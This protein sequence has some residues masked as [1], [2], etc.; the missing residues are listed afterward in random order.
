MAKANRVLKQS[1]K[2]TTAKSHRTLTGVPHAERL[3]AFTEEMAASSAEKTDAAAHERPET[4]EKPVKRFSAAD[5]ARKAGEQIEALV[6]MKVDS[7]SA[8][9][10]LDDGWE[11][12]VNIIELARIPHST[13]VLASYNVSLDKDGD[14]VSYSRGNRY[15]RDQTGDVM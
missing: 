2:R 15:M 9:A 5:A 6:R 12:V 14:L 10:K 8:V 4:T 7:V 1:A 3:M 11:V 13:D